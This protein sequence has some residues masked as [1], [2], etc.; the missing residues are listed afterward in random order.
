MR[1]LPGVGENFQDHVT[2]SVY[3]RTRHPI[4]LLGPDK[5]IKAARHGVQYLLW[6]TRPLTSTVIES[7]ASVASTRSGRPS[8]QN[9]VHTSPWVDFVRAPTPA[10]RSTPHPSVTPHPPAQ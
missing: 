7:G 4:S 2:A 5:G 10:P 9:H 3:G 1:H 8:N 6:P